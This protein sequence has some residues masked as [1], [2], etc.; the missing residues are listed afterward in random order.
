MKADSH[1]VTCLNHGL[2]YFREVRDTQFVHERVSSKVAR[3]KFDYFCKLEEE[4]AH[5]FSTVVPG[6]NLAGMSTQIKR[7]IN[8]EQDKAIWVNVTCSL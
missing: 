7:V 2:L 8:I 5:L 6:G 4:Y 3:E 1:N